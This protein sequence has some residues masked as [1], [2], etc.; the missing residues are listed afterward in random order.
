MSLTKFWM[1]SCD[2][3]RTFIFVQFPKRRLPLD[4]Q[5][6]LGWKYNVKQ[7]Y[8]KRKDKKEEK[9]KKEDQKEL[10]NTSLY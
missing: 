2:I 6:I 4:I 5:K 8:K 3:N 9:D 10:Y 1:S 7:A